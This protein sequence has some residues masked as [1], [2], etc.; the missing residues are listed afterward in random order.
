MEIMGVDRPDRTHGFY[1]VGPYQPEKLSYRVL[2]GGWYLTGGGV[3]GEPF[4]DS[5]REDWGTLGKIR[6]ITPPPLRI[7]L[8][9]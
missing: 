6:E 8:V 9:M 7:L 5:G 4:E 3:P 1:K 2:K